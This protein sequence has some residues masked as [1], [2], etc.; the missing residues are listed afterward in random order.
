MNEELKNIFTN[1]K[2]NGKEIEVSHIKYKGKSK[3]FVTWATLSERP[4][5]NANDEDLYGV[6]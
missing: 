1:F 5:L 6:V 3:T 2:V 4:S